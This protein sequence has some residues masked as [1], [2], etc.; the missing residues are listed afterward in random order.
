MGPGRK[1]SIRR[2]LLPAGE[3][4]S[5]TTGKWLIAPRPNPDAKA[6]LFC[7]PYA[8]GGAG[9][10]PV[11]GATVSTNSVEV[12]AVEPPGRGTRII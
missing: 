5:R 11:L 8:G 1:I 9:I 3:V 12:V 7:F 4:A 10:V 6:R 2:S